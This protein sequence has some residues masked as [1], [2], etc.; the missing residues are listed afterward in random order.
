[1]DLASPY[2]TRPMISSF[3]D[4]LTRSPTDY[5]C[6]CVGFRIQ[7]PISY[8]SVVDQQLN[9]SLS[10]KIANNQKFRRPNFDL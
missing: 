5:E 7:L 8:S 10:L 1:M 6:I 3:S 9:T 4:F 2:T